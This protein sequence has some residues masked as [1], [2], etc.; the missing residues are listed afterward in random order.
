MRT[1]CTIASLG[2]AVLLSMTAP[3]HG[4]AREESGKN[5]APLGRLS[6]GQP[7]VQ[8]IWGAVLGGSVSLTNPISQA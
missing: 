3:V 8:G 2:V 4:Q 6:D 1:E 5:P 7:N